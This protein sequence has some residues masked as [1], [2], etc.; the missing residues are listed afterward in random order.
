MKRVSIFS[1]KLFSVLILAAF[2]LTLSG[3]ASTWVQKSPKWQPQKNVRVLVGHYSVKSNGGADIFDLAKQVAGDISFADVSMESYKL[4]KKSLK[5]FDLNLV[6]DKRRAQKLNHGIKLTSGN[7]RADEL[8]GSLACEWTHPQTSNKPFHR[9]MAGTDLRKQVVNKL[10]GTNRKEV[11]LSA[12]LDIEDQD[13]YLLFK[14]FRVTLSMQILDQ[15]G[16]TVFQAKTEGFTSLKFLRNPISEKRIQ[17]AVADALSKLE[18]VEVENK[19][20]LFTSL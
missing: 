15:K 18:A 12:N 7:K 1:K 11:F 5:K 8:I 13:Q 4:M 9:I 16:E 20:S 10:K 2:S 19:I 3:C 14:R 6:T 17:V